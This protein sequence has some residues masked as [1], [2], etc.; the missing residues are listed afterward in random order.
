MGFNVVEGITLR[1]KPLEASECLTGIKTSKTAEKYFASG[2][3]RE[4]G[5]DV[6][7]PIMYS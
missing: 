6:F 5:S 7:M 2:F 1:E 3:L 4:I